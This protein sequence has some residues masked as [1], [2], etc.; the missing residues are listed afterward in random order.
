V[1]GATG[2]FASNWPARFRRLASA[3]ISIKYLFMG[4]I[5]AEWLAREFT[6]LGIHFQNWMPLALAIVVFG[7]LLQWL[8]SARGN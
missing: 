4:D 2:Y 6:F 8:S 7:V 1:S 5:V 3:K